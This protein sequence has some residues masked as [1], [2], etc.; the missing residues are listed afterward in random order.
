M[1]KFFKLF[2]RLSDKKKGN[3]MILV[4]G[5]PKTG[6]TAVYYSIKEVLPAESICLFEPENRN[7]Q[8]PEI[9]TSPVLVKS[10]VP[11]SKAYDHFNKKIL[12]IRDP[13]DRIISQML[14]RPYNIMLDKFI[15]N[16][17]MYER[18]LQEMLKLLHQK[19][20]D[21]GSVSVKDIR[22]L[23]NL[24]PLDNLNEKLMEY[25]QNRPDVFVYKYEDHIEG[26]LINL[27]QYL[28]F[29]VKK[30]EDVP[31][32]RVIR[33]K[34]YGSWRDWFTPADVAYYRPIFDNFMHMFGYD[35]PWELN[36][37][38]G[39]D[40]SISSRYV[41]KLIEEAK[42]HLISKK[43]EAESHNRKPE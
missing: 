31:E 26:K 37:N 6:T 12:I 34:S 33:S 42:E 17:E 8:L 9:I 28:G 14:Y 5:N 20:K 29:A 41:I 15:T 23:L 38:P 21:P 25:Y 24:E 27:S 16:E 11:F 7:L 43:K 3:P 10:F 36:A 40:P 18:M 19:E 39:I 2:H 32:K 35:D 13:R 1:M 4:T 30:I 22:I